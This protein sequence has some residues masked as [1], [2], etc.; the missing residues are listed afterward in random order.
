MKSYPTELRP[1]YLGVVT[2]QIL[3]QCE[4]KKN[5]FSN[6]KYIFA[7]CDSMSNAFLETGQLQYSEQTEAEPRKLRC[8]VTVLAWPLELEISE[9]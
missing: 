1:I 7:H 8:Q 2:I 3:M 5:V 6:C 9:S 4:C